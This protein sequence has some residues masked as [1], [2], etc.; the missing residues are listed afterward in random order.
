MSEKVDD[1]NLILFCFISVFH[2]TTSSTYEYA[3]RIPTKLFL[4]RI[5]DSVKRLSRSISWREYLVTACTGDMGERNRALW[6]NSEPS[7]GV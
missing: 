6:S 4:E 5:P 3:D 2:F 7:T 1:S